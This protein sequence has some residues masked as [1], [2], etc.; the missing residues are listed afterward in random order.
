MMCILICRV[1]GKEIE[2]NISQLLQPKYTSCRDC[3]KELIAYY[4]KSDTLIEDI[5]DKTNNFYDYN[6]VDKHTEFLSEIC[7]MIH[8]FLKRYDVEVYHEMFMEKFNKISELLE[9]DKKII[10]QQ[11]FE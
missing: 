3:R 2:I 7:Y 8:P 5:I 6:N 11:L 10:L 9:L 4:S 1:C